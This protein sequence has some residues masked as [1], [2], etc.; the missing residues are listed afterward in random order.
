MIVG[1]KMEGL[2]FFNKIWVKG[3]NSEYERKKMVKLSLYWLLSA[4]IVVK[5]LPFAKGNPN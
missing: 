3:S 4:S 5:I 1:R 2:N